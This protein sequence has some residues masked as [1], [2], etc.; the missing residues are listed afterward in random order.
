MKQT[1][2]ET[3]F[4]VSIIIFAALF[5]VGTLPGSVETFPYF[6]W[7]FIPSII[8]LV[9]CVCYGAKESK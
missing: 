3:W 8:N 9:V 2:W 6:L 7:A 1:T 5:L 4:I